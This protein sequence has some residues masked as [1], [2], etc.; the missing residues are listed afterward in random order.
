MEHQCAK[1]CGKCGN[2]EEDGEKGEDS[3]EEENGGGESKGVVKDR[4]SLEE[5]P[6]EEID[7]SKEQQIVQIRG[8]PR[9]K[10]GEY[11]IINK[12]IVMSIV[13]FIV[14]KIGKYFYPL[15]AKLVR[16][17]LAQGQ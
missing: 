4:G 2:E 16:K 12:A 13:M 8:K 9:N 7:S 5:L 1:T 14:F 15:S 17:D 6:E 10:N 11:F 3:G